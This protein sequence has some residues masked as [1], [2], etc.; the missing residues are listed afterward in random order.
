MR[1]PTGVAS[2]V[3]ME[4]TADPA[5][6]VRLPAPTSDRAETSRPYRYFVIELLIVT[7][8]VLIAL[9]VDSLR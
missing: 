5:P 2:L 8:G 7:S 4:H 3:G 6:E 1:R 9:S